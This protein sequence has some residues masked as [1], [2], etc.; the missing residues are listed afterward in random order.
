MNVYSSLVGISLRNAVTVA[1]QSFGKHSFAT[2]EKLFSMRSVPRGYLE[3]IWGD[4]GSSWGLFSKRIYG[5]VF[6]GGSETV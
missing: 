1:R 4:P 3:D 6:G 5:G 2:T